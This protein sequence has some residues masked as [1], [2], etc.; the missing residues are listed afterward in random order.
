MYTFPSHDLLSSLVELYFANMNIYLPILHRP[1]FED[2]LRQ[3]LHLRDAEFG[4]VVLLVCAIGARLSNDPR[5]LTEGTNDWH[6]AGFQ[7]FSQIIR[8][9]DTLAPSFDV[10]QLQAVTVRVYDV[11]D[12]A[13]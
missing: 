3:C 6:S 11:F 4:A 7:W 10:H 13:S 9:G 12:T 2:Q 5:V 8:F 1:I